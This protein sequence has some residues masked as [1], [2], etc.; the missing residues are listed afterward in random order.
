MKLSK[1]YTNDTLK[2]NNNYEKKIQIIFIQEYN[3]MKNENRDNETIELIETPNNY[4]GK[5]GLIRH[6]LEDVKKRKNIH[7][8]KFGKLKKIN[9]FIKSFVNGLNA[10]SVCSLIL[11]LTPA[12]SIVSIIALSATSI[13]A[14][15]SAVSS[16]M[17]LEG[18]I[19]SHNTSNLQ[20]NDLYRDVSARLLRNGMSSEDLDNLLSEINTR[21]SLI[22]DSSLPINY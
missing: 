9:T 14:T 5:V 17:D 15:I 13:S 20:Y 4:M 16:S 12:T 3:K 11:S 22:E 7:Y 10:V 2:I 8:K 1:L 6:I 18:K 19:H 21:M